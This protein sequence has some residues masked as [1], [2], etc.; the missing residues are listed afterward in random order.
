M[1]SS[2]CAFFFCFFPHSTLSFLHFTLYTQF[3][4]SASYSYW[5]LSWAALLRER[6]LSLHIITK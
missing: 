6:C 2:I 3:S 1:S 4:S 5:V